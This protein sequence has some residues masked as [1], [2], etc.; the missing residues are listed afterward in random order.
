MTAAAIAVSVDGG[1]SYVTGI[2]ADG[3][4]IL[5]RIYAVGINADYINTGTI[6][7]NDSS[8]NP[9]LKL[10]E[11]AETGLSVKNPFTGNGFVPLSKYAFAQ[12]VFTTSHQLPELT[13]TIKIDPS[14]TSSHYTQSELNTFL[15]GKS[16]SKS[17]S[18]VIYKDFTTTDSG[19]V[20]IDVTAVCSGAASGGFYTYYKGYSKTSSSCGIYSNST[21]ELTVSVTEQINGVVR[22]TK[23]LK[24]MSG[25]AVTSDG[26]GSETDLGDTP[27]NTRL[28]MHLDMNEKFRVSI[29]ASVSTTLTGFVNDEYIQFVNQYYAAHTVKDVSILVTP[30][31]T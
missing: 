2:T 6:T 31:G 26:T 19:Y 23:K 1:K 16:Q 13:T 7:V 14:E 11:G 29:D 30:C 17:V 5:N 10:G 4:A 12:P 27:Q 25:T 9:I 24:L 28:F 20:V 15:S 8:G 18:N 21:T 3:N 22:E